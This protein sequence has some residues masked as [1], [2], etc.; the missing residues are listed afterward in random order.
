MHKLSAWSA[1]HKVC[2]LVISK[3]VVIIQP[4]V[5][6]FPGSLKLVIVIVVPLSRRASLG[7][8]LGSGSRYWFNAVR[9]FWDKSKIFE[10]GIKLYLLH[11]DGDLVAL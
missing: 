5:L 3:I 11:L 10:I 7:Q 8:Y 1:I 9:G 4:M 2:L 6:K